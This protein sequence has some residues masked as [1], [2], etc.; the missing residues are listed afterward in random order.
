MYGLA[1]RITRSDSPFEGD[2]AGAEIVP[3]FPR[4]GV[5]V[6]ERDG[7]TT[8]EL[9]RVCLG[10]TCAIAVAADAAGALAQVPDVRPGVILI[11]LRIDPAA[12]DVLVDGLAAAGLDAIPVITIDPSEPLNAEALRGRIAA[13]LRVSRRVWFGGGLRSRLVA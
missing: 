12:V 13:A 7:S 8:V 10:D 3:L 9:V 11:D 1:D 4:T 2:S 6:L 5:L